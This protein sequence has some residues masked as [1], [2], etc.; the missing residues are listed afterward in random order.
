M[1]TINSKDTESMEETP[2]CPKCEI[3]M[4]ISYTMRGYQFICKNYHKCGGRKSA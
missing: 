3:K 2:I 4:S 1:V